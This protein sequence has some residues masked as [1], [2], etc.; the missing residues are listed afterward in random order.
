MPES[1]TDRS[2]RGE[3]V[4]VDSPDMSLGAP[5]DRLATHEGRLWHLTLIVLLS[6][7]VG[8][9]VVSWQQ[10]KSLP[11]ELEA[12]P[13]GLVVLVALFGAYTLA[14]SREIN[15]LRGLVR[16]LEQRAASSPDAEQVE[17]LFD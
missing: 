15:A 2:P 13:I 5:L 4:G 16:G 7:A 3:H 11:W 14:K 6:L 17:K 12:L 8:L 9:A 10:L 1:T